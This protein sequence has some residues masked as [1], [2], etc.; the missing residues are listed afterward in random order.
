MLGVKGHA[1][2]SCC[3]KCIQR[4]ERKENRMIFH[5]QNHPLRT[6]IN[7]WQRTDVSHHNQ[8]SSLEIEKLPIDVIQVFALDYMH[9]VYLGV[10]K[11]LLGS[12]IKV[13]NCNYSLQ[14]NDIR[15]L[16]TEFQ[17]IACYIPRDFCRKPRD[18][19]EID[20]F[21]ATE[22]RQFLLYTGQ[23]VLKDIL[24]EEMYIHFLQLS[25]AM[26]ILLNAEDCVQNNKCA[27]ELIKDFL[28]RVPVLYDDLM[29]TYNCHCLSHLARD[30]MHFGS[31][32]TTSA[33]KF[34]N[35]L[36]KIKKLVK[37]KNNVPSQIYN[38]LVEQSVH[39]NHHTNIVSKKSTVQ[40]DGTYKFVKT[41]NFYLSSI[42]PE[43][44]YLVQ[45]LR[46][47]GTRLT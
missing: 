32:E 21:K 37:K 16:N 8:Q 25:L 23:V 13:K 17:S 40:S 11:A 43:N 41:K 45:K 7:F 39:G 4:G 10:M 44:F 33:F 29:L 14:Q 5:Y 46:A 38:R 6:N 2:Y 9:V 27:E 30:S 35:K 1:G 18:L 36:G 42:A 20:R 47:K 3:T 26:R 34:E 31:L 28:L 19:K 24:S 22:F 12:W 15:K